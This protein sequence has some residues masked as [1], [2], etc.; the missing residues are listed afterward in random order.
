MLQRKNR[1]RL[2]KEFNHVFKHGSSSYCKYIGVRVLDNKKGVS[3]LGVV[4][5]TKVSKKAVVRNKIKRIFRDFFQQEMHLISKPF[6]VVIIALPGIDKLEKK[7]INESLR[8]IFIKL[9]IITNK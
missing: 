2:K 1:I 4:V 3:R 6:D 7:E 8:E 9:N 5:S